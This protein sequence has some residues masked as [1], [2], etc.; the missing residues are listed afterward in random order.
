MNFLQEFEAL[1]LKMP[2]LYN[3]NVGCENS[4]YCTHADK[5]KNCYLVFAINF[6]EDCMYGGIVLNSKDCVDC[7]NCEYSELCYECVDIDHCYNCIFSQDLKN[8][9][10]C[11]FCYDCVGSK[12][13]F[14]CVGLRQKEYCI[15][16]E[17]VG[18]ERYR[19]FLKGFDARNKQSIREALSKLDDLQLKI[20][21]K[22]MHETQAEA[23]IGDYIGRSKN[24]FNC[25]NIHESEDCMYMQDC[26]R[27]VDSLDMTFSD[28]STLCYDS[29]SIG[30]G[31]YNCNFSNY[32]RSSRD[33]EYCE[34]CFNCKDCFGC[35][36]L[37]DKQ[38][39]ILNQ[40]LS[41]EEYFAKVAELKAEMRTKGTYGKH[42][43][44][45]YIYEDT[46]AVSQ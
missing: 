45:T 27:T 11:H 34:L 32:I 30:L 20:P 25:F 9:S 42:L 37:K 14:G 46:A 10:D 35:I 43:P 17:Y 7:L 15:Y 23:C 5:D 22:F 16:N 4:D 12:N 3:I 33:L 36:G 39:H 18:K 26:W 13:C 28:G 40:P 21:R 1:R 2:R 8:S 44:T 6:S 19:E 29:F 24:C 41:R 31:S 38:Y